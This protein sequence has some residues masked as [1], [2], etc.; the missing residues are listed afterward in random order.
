VT[1]TDAPQRSE[2]W[3]EA[4]RGLPTCSRFDRIMTAAKGQRSA[5][6][7]GL[8]NELIGEMLCPPEQGL[9]R[10]ATS[11]MEYGLKLEAEARCCYELEHATQPVREVGFVTADC[12]MFGGSPDA[13]VGESGGV[14]IKCPNASTHIGYIRSDELP[15][16]YKCQ[17]HG[18]LVVTGRK[19]WD[20]FSYHRGVFPFRLRVHRDDFTDRLHA[21]LLEFC[22][23][24]NQARALFDLPPLG[25]A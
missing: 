2:A 19:W 11:E 4:R 13:L 8:I 3:F 18:Y 6:Q 12:G 24:Y 14:E 10:P 9:I 1:T 23:R 21:E 15:N 5:A 25:S 16:E 17:V 20:F 7:D 22:K